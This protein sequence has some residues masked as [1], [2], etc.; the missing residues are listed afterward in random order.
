[1]SALSVIYT[2]HPERTFLLPVQGVILDY[3]N[4]LH[5]GV[6]SCC[7]HIANMCLSTASTTSSSNYDRPNRLKGRE[8]GNIRWQELLEKFRSV[9]ER[10]RR[11]QR[12]GLDGEDMPFIG[13]SEMRIG[14]GAMDPK[15][16]DTR[17]PATTTPTPQK[18]PTPAPPVPAKRTGLGRQFG[19]LG[20]A[21]AGKNRRN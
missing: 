16:K 13:M 14:D 9:Q 6:P 8:D 20:G 21:V 12:Q 3:A 1:M 18:D 4:V 10:A 17:T 7:T 11:A 15:G 2:W 19:R 5:P